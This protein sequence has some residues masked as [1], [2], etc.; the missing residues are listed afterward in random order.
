MSG[1]SGSGRGDGLLNGKLN[2]VWLTVP[3][4]VDPGQVDTVVSPPRK[5]PTMT[6]LDRILAKSGK[7]SSGLSSA[8]QQLETTP[9]TP[10][11]DGLVPAASSTPTPTPTPTPPP[12][13]PVPK[14]QSAAFQSSTAKRSILQ[15][16]SRD[17]DAE[18]L[19]VGHVSVQQYR[20][21]ASTGPSPSLSPAPSPPA[22]VASPPSPRSNE[23]ECILNTS[24]QVRELCHGASALLRLGEARC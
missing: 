11:A 7:P 12:I 18:V 4:P 3:V 9:A 10:A 21:P 8:A 22:A 14:N 5:Q 2:L 24:V 15:Q 16:Y 23:K 1:G 19:V 20:S 17:G 13:P 6:A